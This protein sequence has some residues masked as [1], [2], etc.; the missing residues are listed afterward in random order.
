MLDGCQRKRELLLAWQGATE[1]YA[2]AVGELSRK[3]GQISEHEYEELRRDAER[4]R[5]ISAKTRSALEMHSK[6]HG[7]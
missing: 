2:R 1:A 4:A 5:N 3:I 7:C 6:E